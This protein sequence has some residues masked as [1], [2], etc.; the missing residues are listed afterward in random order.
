M[1]DPA[2]DHTEGG[3]RRP[4]ADLLWE[5]LAGRDLGGD[6]IPVVARLTCTCRWKTTCC[7]AGPAT[8]VG[9][10][11]LGVCTVRRRPVT[12]R[13]RCCYTTRAADNSGPLFCH[14]LTPSQPVAFATARA[15]YT[16][17]Q[18]SLG[19]RTCG[20]VEI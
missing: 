14:T 5:P 8:S 17:D 1:R 12:W 10:R 15:S 18:C 11:S 9:L 3:Q 7:A 6:V 13:C 4:K 2:E 19:D 16:S 20:E